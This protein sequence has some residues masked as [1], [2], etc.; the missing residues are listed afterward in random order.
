MPLDLSA[1]AASFTGATLRSRLNSL[2]G[3][4]L[5]GPL[6]VRAY[7]ATGDGATD[8]TAAIEDALAAASS[9]VATYGGADVRLPAGTY[10]LGTSGLTIPARVGL[11]ADSGATLVY[12]GTG[13]ALTVEGSADAG[14]RRLVLPNLRRGSA[15]AEPGW[16]S[17]ADTTS[18]GVDLR[19]CRY[20]QVT[21]REVRGFATGLR[22]QA[23]ADGNCVCNTV[24]L[25]RLVNNRAGLAFREYRPGASEDLRGANQNTILGGVVRIDSAYKAAGCIYID[26]PEAENNG[27]LFLGV[28]LE[29]AS[30][31]VVAI[32]CNSISNTWLN[33]RFENA[34]VDGATKPIQFGAASAKNRIWGTMTVVT[35]DG[36]W[37]SIVEDQGG[38]NEYYSDG[39]LATKYL[40]INL[41]LG[42]LLLGNGAAAPAWRIAGYGTDR[43][44][45]GISTG[46]GTRYYQ[47]MWQEEVEQ[48]SGTTL[49]TYVAHHTLNYA[50]PAMITGMQGG[51][52]SDLSGLMSVFSKTANV[53]LQ[54]SA[55]PTAGKFVMKAGADK[56]MTANSTVLF[57]LVDGVF[58]E[59]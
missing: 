12:S 24:H 3:M 40:K 29:D 49:P 55:S 50:A 38:A 11:V 9:R 48:T 27:N 30:G 33:C 41:E 43:G 23:I 44:Q 26:M 22:L 53:T 54:H 4:A 39:A 31:G 28:N 5:Y 56:A 52:P 20:D 42:R 14:L 51:A 16:F 21:A 7:G 18:V 36:P 25:G 19:G 2:L 57:R 15:D 32:L 45:I 35:Q 17:G 59:T 6:D 58:Y 47:S 1:L 34:A 8:D 46:R 37:L 13:T 10:N